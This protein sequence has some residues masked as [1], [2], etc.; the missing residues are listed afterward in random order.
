M[1]TAPGANLAG[2]PTSSSVLGT[3]SL[4]GSMGTHTHTQ[5]PTKPRPGAPRLDKA[6]D[7]GDHRTGFI[8]ATVISHFSL[9]QNACF[10]PMF[11]LDCC[12]FLIDSWEFLL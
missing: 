9:Q 11:L 8:G 3:S 1:A 5:I 6:L 10:L 12:L 2:P 7:G 4:E